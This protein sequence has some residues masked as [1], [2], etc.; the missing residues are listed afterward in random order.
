VNERPRPARPGLGFTLKRIRRT[1][2]QII[3][4]LTTAEELI[5]QGKAFADVCRA[6]GM[7][8]LE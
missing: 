3:R 6:I 5:A 4:N 7:T 1:P 2:E 8:R